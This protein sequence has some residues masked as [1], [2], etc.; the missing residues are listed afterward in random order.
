MV[1]DKGVI[2]M[3]VWILSLGGCIHVSCIVRSL[4]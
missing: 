4:D 2:E 3:G 1:Y